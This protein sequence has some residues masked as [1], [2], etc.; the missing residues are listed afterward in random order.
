MKKFD[1][2]NF[3][4]EEIGTDKICEKLYPELRRSFA[5][6]M[7]IPKEK[8][9]NY[10]LQIKN[11]GVYAAVEEDNK[12]YSC[13]SVNLVS[14]QANFHGYTD[15]FVTVTPFNVYLTRNCVERIQDKQASRALREYMFSIYGQEW[16]DEFKKFL[17]EVKSKKEEVE[18]KA[19]NAKLQK[20]DNDYE[21][22]VNSIN[23]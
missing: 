17:L 14:F 12:E 22:E 7:Y 18:T 3:S 11:K 16:F 2:N 8:K 19:Y 6:L 1:L 20:I 9:E 15:L 5:E 10:S 21:L 23:M 4:F 13:V